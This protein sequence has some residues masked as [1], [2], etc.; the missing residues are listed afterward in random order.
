MAIIITKTNLNILGILMLTLFKIT[1]Y[2][3][4]HKL[5]EIPKLLIIITLIL[6]ETEQLQNSNKIIKDI[7]TYHKNNNNSSKKD[8]PID[9]PIN[10]LLLS[11]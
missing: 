9:S 1:N 11:S 2:N 4:I 7:P 5:P 6:T 10:N 8:F 3:S